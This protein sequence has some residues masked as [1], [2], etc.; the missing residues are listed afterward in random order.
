MFTVFYVKYLFKRF[1]LRYN[2]YVS[3]M[4]WNNYELWQRQIQ[5]LVLSFY[6]TIWNCVHKLEHFTINLAWTIIF[7]VS[8]NKWFYFPS[9]KNFV[10]KGDLI[11]SLID[12]FGVGERIKFLFFF[13][14]VDHQNYNVNYLYW[15]WRQLNTASG[16]CEDRKTSSITNY[17]IIMS[18][19]ATI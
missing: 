12:L 11:K 10:N 13:Y 3:W 14:V 2:L 15:M 17:F 9:H 8:I 4:W 7:F 19:D 5:T 16:L 18:I 6:I 1:P